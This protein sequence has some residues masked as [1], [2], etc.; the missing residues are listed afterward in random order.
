MTRKK[1]ARKVG[2]EGPAQYVEKNASQLDVEGRK[3][4]KARKRKGLKSGARNAQ[5][6][7]T[8]AEN[9]IIIQKDPRLG[10]K[11]P[12]PLV[13]DNTQVKAR[14]TLTAEQE[15]EKLE[16]DAQLNVLLDRLD[17]GEKLG[18]GLQKYVDEK[19]DRIAEL[20]DELGLLDE[21]E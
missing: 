10:S 2:S 13:V 17:A 11:K 14:K 4:Q 16:N 8:K 15:L 18:A 6:L 3:R 19:L 12:F 1:K 20:M 9:S 7:K 5:N 21:D